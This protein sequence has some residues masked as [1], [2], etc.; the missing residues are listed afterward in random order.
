MKKEKKKGSRLKTVLIVFGALIVLGAIGSAFGDDEKASTENS[1]SVEQM[2]NEPD[3]TATNDSLKGSEESINDE[4]SSEI[5]SDTSTDPAN[6]DPLGFNVMFSDTYRNDTTGN[7]RLARIAE[8]IN[9]E[10]Y[11]VDYYNN[12]FQADSEI[13]IIINF[14][15]NTTT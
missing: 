12:Y 7:W 10:E 8:D 9:I 3:S 13:H 5:L 2:E 4:S 14:N 15:L 1:R 11:A 6:E